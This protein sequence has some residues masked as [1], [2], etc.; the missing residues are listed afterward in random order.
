[1]RNKGGKRWF[2]VSFTLEE[3]IQMIN[4]SLACW[5]GLL[6]WTRDVHSLHFC[7]TLVCN[8]KTHFYCI[9]RAMKVQCENVFWHHFRFI[10]RHKSSKT[11]IG[12]AYSEWAD[13]F[14]E[15]VL[16]SLLSLCAFENWTVWLWAPFSIKSVLSFVS[17]W[18]GKHWVQGKLCKPTSLYCTSQRYSESIMNICLIMFCIS[19]SVSI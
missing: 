12:R 19:C 15:L 18:R 17:G 1:M 7:L 6:K 4:V 9:W 3:V 14:D 10:T 16:F 11:C 2:S 13:R 5:T 8:D